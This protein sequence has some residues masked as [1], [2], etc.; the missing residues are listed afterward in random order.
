MEP[1]T[2]ESAD[3][4]SWRNLDAPFGE[5]AAWTGNGWVP[6]HIWRCT[7]IEI[8]YYNKMH[9]V[10]LS[11]LFKY[12]TLHSFGGSLLSASTNCDS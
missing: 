12:K 4:S 8:C 11:L 5:E 3:V 7:R 10:T 9:L 6:E 2:P 1:E